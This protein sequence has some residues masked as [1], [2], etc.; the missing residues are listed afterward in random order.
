MPLAVTCKLGTNSLRQ[1]EPKYFS[2]PRVLVGGWG[3]SRKEPSFLGTRLEVKTSV[4][5]QLAETQGA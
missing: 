4:Q 5:V 3:D 1:N 2:D